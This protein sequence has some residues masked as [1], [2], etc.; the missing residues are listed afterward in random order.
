MRMDGLVLTTLYVANTWGLI[1]VLT[2]LRARLAAGESTSES[3]HRRLANCEIKSFQWLC[4][5]HVPGLSHSTA[6]Q[7]NGGRMTSSSTSQINCPIVSF[8]C[9]INKVRLA[10]TCSA[11]EGQ[12]RTEASPYG[13]SAGRR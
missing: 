8:L 11:E 13:A 7:I 2:A 5:C 3:F 9:F 6:T 1:D 12:V 4:F 10:N